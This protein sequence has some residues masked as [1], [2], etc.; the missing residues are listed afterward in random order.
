MLTV[1]LEQYLNLRSFNFVEPTEWYSVINIMYFRP[2]LALNFLEK[3][4]N[5]DYV[6][7]VGGKEL[8]IN[9]EVSFSILDIVIILRLFVNQSFLWA[10]LMHL[11][12]AKTRFLSIPSLKKKSFKI[13]GQFYRVFKTRK[14][15]SFLYNF[16]V[17]IFTSFQIKFFCVVAVTVRANKLCQ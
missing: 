5:S 13:S 10:S 6:L 16:N 1:I 9:K 12:S 8:Y 15:C 3:S 7:K 11:F 4:E 2:Y 17:H 14:I